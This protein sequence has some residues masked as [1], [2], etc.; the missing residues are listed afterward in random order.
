M[1]NSPDPSRSQT[2]APQGATLPSIPDVALSTL[3]DG[4][5]IIAMR[6]LRREDLAQEAAQETLARVLAAL[7]EG[8]LTGAAQLGPYAYGVLRHVII[9][10]QRGEARTQPW[11]PLMDVTSSATDALEQLVARETS[12]GVRRAL[13]ALSTADRLLLQRCFMQGLRVSEIA[14]RTG[15]PEGRLRQRKLRALARLRALLGNRTAT[16]STE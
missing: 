2:S 12:T 8:R 9:D 1:V 10:M 14:R 4:L 11:A 6:R 15:E 3:R 5:V 7:Q 16:A 13:Q